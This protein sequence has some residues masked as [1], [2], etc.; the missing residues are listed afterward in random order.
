MYADQDGS[1]CLRSAQTARSPSSAAVTLPAIAV[2]APIPPS[3]HTRCAAHH[4]PLRSRLPKT[5]PVWPI[6]PVPTQPGPY[7]CPLALPCL[8]PLVLNQFHSLR[9]PYAGGIC[10]LRLGVLNFVAIC[11]AKR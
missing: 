11:R 5:R 8:L 2:P 10:D 7:L 4:L 1:A 6:N 3:P 9:K